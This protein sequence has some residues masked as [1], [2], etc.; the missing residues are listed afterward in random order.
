MVKLKFYPSNV[1]IEPEAENYPLCK[2]LINKFKFLNIPVFN[3]K[4]FNKLNNFEKTSREFYSFSK[5]SLIVGIKKSMKLECCKPSADYQFSLVTGCP[6]SC[7]YC[8]LQ[9]NQSFKPFIKVYVNIEEIFNNIDK[10]I[11]S[12]IPNITTFEISSSSDPIAVEHITGSV[13]KTIEFFSNK[14]F[15]RLRLVTKYSNIDNLL[16]INHNNHT[17]VR[18]SINSEYV[19]KNFEHNT[20][21]IED[22]IKAASLI[23]KSGYPLGFII[24]PIMYY[25]NWEEEYRRLFEMLKNNIPDPYTKNISFELIQYRF[26]VKAKNIILE[27]FPNTKLDMKEE[28]RTKKWGP[29]GIYKFVYPKDTSIKLKEY[30]SNLIIE[31]FPNSTIEYFT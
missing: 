22:R 7:E 24:A 28:S 2:E 19:I 8:Y 3:F 11:N 17:K 5:R 9:T 15:G 21:K 26:T 1:F 6:G 29:Y 13:R 10:Y 4:D 16:N 14:E 27:R 25:D 20:D 31:Y 23:Y 12:S 18:F 30:I